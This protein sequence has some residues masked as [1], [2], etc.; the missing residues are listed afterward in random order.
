MI[1]MIVS[2]EL[3][4]DIEKVMENLPVEALDW[5]PGPEMNSIAVLVVH[6]DRRR[7]ILDWSGFE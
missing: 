1:F 6:L 3:H 7:T 4:A 5:V 2:A